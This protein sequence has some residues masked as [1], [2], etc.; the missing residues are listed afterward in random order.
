MR[1]QR[2]EIRTHIYVDRSVPAISPLLYFFG[3]GRK[4]LRRRT[5]PLGTERRRG[6]RSC[7]TNPGE[8]N[9]RRQNKEKIT[10][11]H[12]FKPLHSEGKKLQY[13]KPKSQQSRHALENVLGAKLH[14][15]RRGTGHQAA[16]AGG[17]CGAVQ[18]GMVGGRWP[19]SLKRRSSQ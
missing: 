7:D 6:H 8:V 2:A 12:P 17:R 11:N 19:S 14:S 15:T 13:L 16:A 18:C 5:A 9:I 10:Q 4:L 3:F 1:G